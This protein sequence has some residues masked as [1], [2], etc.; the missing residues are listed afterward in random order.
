MKRLVI[1]AI[2]FGLAFAAA[3]AAM[4][5]TIGPPEIDVA[6]AT[7]QIASSPFKPS[8]CVGMKGVPYVTYRG[9]W[10]GGETDLTHTTPYNLTG[11]LSVPNVVWTI[12]L[13]TD[14]GLLHGTAT[15]TDQPASGAPALTTYSGPITLVTQ[16][17]PNSTDKGV[18]ARGWINAPTYT[19]GALDGGSVVANVELN[20]GGGFAANGEFGGSMGFTDFSVWTNNKVC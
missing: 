8:H 6:S 17:L 3:G 11:T 12:N 16:G 13:K 15:L 7:I 4:A 19:K 9:S 2:T 5:M 20:I 18:E 1:P 10:K 14:R